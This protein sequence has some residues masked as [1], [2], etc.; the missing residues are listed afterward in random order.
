MLMMETKTIRVDER[1]ECTSN[2]C[3]FE[4][5]RRLSDTVMTAATTLHFK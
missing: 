2:Q 5:D 4:D 1:G 3:Y